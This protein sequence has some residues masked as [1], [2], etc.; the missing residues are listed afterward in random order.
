MYLIP[1]LLY[2]EHVYKILIKIKTNWYIDM[3]SKL[4][5]CFANKHWT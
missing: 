2:F 3:F 4:S 5:W 1:A